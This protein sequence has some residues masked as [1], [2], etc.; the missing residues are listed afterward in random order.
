MYRVAV[1]LFSSQALMRSTPQ[2]GQIKSHYFWR[3]C[4]VKPH[5][6]PTIDDEATPAQECVHVKIMTINYKY[7]CWVQT[8]NLP[9]FKTRQ[10]K[11][12]KMSDKNLILTMLNLF[13]SHEILT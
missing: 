7:I 11:L 6:N 8:W 9:S 1:L 13:F 2:L 4:R 5:K 3:T 10:R 12:E